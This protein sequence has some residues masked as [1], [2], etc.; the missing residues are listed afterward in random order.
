MHRGGYQSQRWLRE[1]ADASADA[2]SP[3]GRRVRRRT[4]DAP[5]LVEVAQTVKTFSGTTMQTI[6][7]PTDRR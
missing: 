7:E 2:R 6:M 5:T 3:I 4:N 1:R